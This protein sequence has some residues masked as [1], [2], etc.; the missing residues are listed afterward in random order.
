M[1]VET[2]DRLGINGRGEEEEWFAD[3]VGDPGYRDSRE[4]GRGCVSGR[5]AESPNGRPDSG[6]VVVLSLGLAW[7]LCFWSWFVAPGTGTVWRTEYLHLRTRRTRA[8][9]R[10]AFGAW[11]AW[12]GDDRGGVC[13]PGR[14]ARG[15]VGF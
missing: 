8:R 7:A 1:E 10:V 9:D 6:R 12:G 13:E 14:G 5:V 15:G 3:G 4:C 11:G 2:R